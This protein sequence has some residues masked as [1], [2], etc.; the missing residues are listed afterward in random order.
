MLLYNLGKEVLLTAFHLGLTDASNY[1]VGKQALM[2]YSS[3]V[4][5]PEELRTKFH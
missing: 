1:D 2:Q 3:P 4:E 5:T